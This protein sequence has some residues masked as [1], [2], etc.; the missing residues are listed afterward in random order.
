M[1]YL[2]GLS[3]EQFDALYS[4]LDSI[5]PLDDIVAY[6]AKNTI[7]VCCNKRG[8]DNKFTNREK[9]FICFVRL[10]RGFTLKTVS[11]L[12]GSP[13][14]SVEQTIIRKIFTTFVQFM[15]KVFRDME[16][17]MFPSWTIMVGYLPRVL[18]TMKKIR[19]IVD[20]TET[21]V[22]TSRNFARQRKAYSA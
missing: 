14:K 15:Y 7:G 9:L 10:R 21:S 6:R 3:A 17:V 18:K 12:L 22:K 1:K 19:C 16:T 13:K 20:C 11:I 2:T 4:F 5:C 8:R